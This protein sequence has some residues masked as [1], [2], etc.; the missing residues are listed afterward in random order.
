M[1]I[2]I[3]VIVVIVIVIGIVSFSLRLKT[4]GRHMLTKSLIACA[5]QTILEKVS[6]LNP[7]LQQTTDLYLSIPIDLI[8]AQS[9]VVRIG[10]LVQYNTQVDAFRFRTTSSVLRLLGG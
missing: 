5:F 9:L 4:Q 8:A 2:V 3:V 10:R 6:K 1:I 7:S